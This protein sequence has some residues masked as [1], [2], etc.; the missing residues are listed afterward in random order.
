MHR[1]KKQFSNACVNISVLKKGGSMETYEVEQDNIISW[2]LEQA[3]YEEL[4]RTAKALYSI[5]VMRRKRERPGE[6][7]LAK[8]AKKTYRKKGFRR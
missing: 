7:K 6:Q 2:G 5:Y 8:F 1:F 3:S 4:E